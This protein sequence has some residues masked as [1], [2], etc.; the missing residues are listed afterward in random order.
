MSCDSFKNLVTSNLV[1]V[2]FRLG[3]KVVMDKESYAALPEEALHGSTVRS[4]SRREALELAAR[5]RR[6]KN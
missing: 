1:E 3:R 6:P 5:G 2:K 4:I